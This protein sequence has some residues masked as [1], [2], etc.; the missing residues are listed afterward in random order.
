MEKTMAVYDVEPRYADRFADVTNQKEKVPFQ[1]V[2]FTSLE[3]LKEYAREHTIEILL[4]SS[5]VP[6][7]LVKEIPAGQVVVLA[8]G[9]VVPAPK[10][11][12]SVYKYQSTDSIIREVLAHYCEQPKTAEYVIVGTKAKILGVYSP[13]GRCLKTSFSWTLGQQLGK[14]GK[15][16]LVSMEE[17]SGFSRLVGEEMQSDLADVFYFY[18]QGNC[19]FARLSSMIYTWGNLDYIPPVRYPEDL[20][21]ITGEEMAEFLTRI[22]SES[23]YEMLVVDMGNVGRH[24]IPMMDACDAVYMP[25]KDDCVSAAK[26]EEFEAYLETSGKRGLLEKIQRVKLPYH[27]GFGRRDTYLEQLVW[28]ELGDY[29]R[30]LLK[31]K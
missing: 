22:A 4:I 14:N 29:V 24:A 17:Y 20:G 28:G 23:S 19:S 21:Q 5:A 30:Q 7:E 27:S 11:Y 10:E 31:G 25:V 8:D 26:L 2:A 16:L 15:T 12:P 13:I 1:V 18:R 9:E 3:A 6:K